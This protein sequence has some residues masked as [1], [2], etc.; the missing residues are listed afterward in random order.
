MNTLGEIKAEVLVELGADTTVAYYTDTI[1]DKWINKAHIW[2]SG[3]K[4]WTF[5]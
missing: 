1:L 5:T 4:K 3:Y 2:S